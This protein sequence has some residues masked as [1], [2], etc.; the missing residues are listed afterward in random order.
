MAAYT[1]VFYISIGFWLILGVE[2]GWSNHILTITPGGSVTIPCHYNETNPHQKK[3]WHSE[4]D[5]SKIYT[6]TSEENLSVIDHPDQSLFTVTM[7][8]LQD[9]D[10]GGYSCVVETDGLLTFGYDLHLRVQPAPDVSVVS[11]SVSGHEGCNVRVQCFYSSRYQNEL[12]QWCRYKDQSCYTVGRTE[13]SQRSSVQISD[14][15]R[16]SFTVL[17]NGLRLSDSGWYFCS[18]GEAMNPVQLTVTKAKQDVL[19]PFVWDAVIIHRRQEEGVECGWSNHFLTIKP[20]GSVTIPCHYNETNPPQKKY[21]SSVYGKFNKYTNTSEE[22]LSVIDHPD[23]SLF[24]VTMRNLQDKDTGGYSCAVETDGLSTITYNIYL[25]VQPAPVV[26]VVSSSVSGHEGG[27]VSVQCF[28]SSGYQDKL[29]QWCRYKDQSCYTVGRTD[30]SQNSSVQI[31]DD[32]RRSFTVLMTGL[33]LSDSGWFFCSARE[34]MNPVQLTVIID[35]R[36]NK[37][38]LTVWLPVSAA[39]LLLLILVGVIFTWRWKQ[40]S[41]QDKHQIIERNDSRTSDP[42]Y[43]EPEDPVIYNIINDECSNKP[44]TGALMY[45]LVGPH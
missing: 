45:S 24:T 5:K 18:A 20:G 42:I 33:R 11:S 21:W 1:K 14:D 32:G 8:N 39:L 40:R 16:S 7:R 36:R 15:G 26:S 10:T 28:Y 31:S 17:M 38:L 22:N 35:K 44:P 41:K 4:I 2:C 37:E 27:N 30:T 9:K 12:K 34:A 19:L 25:R 29:K 3:Y 43:C 13:T 6:N 23:Q